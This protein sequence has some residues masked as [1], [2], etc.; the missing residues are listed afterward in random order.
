MTAADPRRWMW[1]EA[2]AMIERAEQLH[3]QFFQ[4]GFAEVPAPNWEPP[5]DIFA[6]EGALTIIAALPGVEPLDI[7]ISIEP[8]LLRVAGVRRLPAAARGMAI[9]R[10]ELPHGRF[11]R[12]IRLPAAQW[13]LE[14]S[15]LAN[16][17][18]L[19]SLINRH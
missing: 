19:L 12:C 17:C 15:T 7:E 8:E 10:L 18:L 16:G 5:L 13:E 11:E 3:R 4:P 14:Q 1:A 2:C 6:T 9:Q